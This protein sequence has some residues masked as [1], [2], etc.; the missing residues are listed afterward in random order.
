MMIRPA[1]YVLASL[2]LLFLFHLPAHAQ[3][4]AGFTTLEIGDSAPGFDLPGIDDKNHQLSQYADAKVL[5]VLFTCNHCPTAQAYEQRLN[6]LYAD[7]SGKGV[8]LV[9]ISPNDPTAVRLDELGYS[10]LGDTLAD[11]KV[12]AKQAG[13][14]YPY[15]YD[16]ENQKVSLAYGVRAT[17]HVF[18]FDQQRKLQYKG[19]IDDSEV[20]TPT[21]HDARNAIDAL[22]ADEEV[23]VQ[24][25]RPF[26]CSTKWM[27]KR[28]GAVESIK[29]WSAEPVE[30][31]TIDQAQLTALVANETDSYRLVN[32][33]ATWC[34]PCIEELPAFVE[35]NRMYRARSF[36][37]VTVC[38]DSIDAQENA[39]KILKDKNVSCRNVLFDS[40][41]DQDVLF[42]TVDAKWEGGVPYTLLIAP[43]GEIVYR[44][45]SAIDPAALKKIIAD[46]LG[47]T[48]AE[49]K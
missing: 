17:P 11:M 22:L 4:P 39:L 16:G 42:D 38:A 28:A 47:R 24:V 1:Q 43:G 21:S 40:T 33:W 36:E 23:P 27:T 10:D 44:Q 19:R 32:I 13:Y 6:E 34:V 29:K 26:G 45:H 5:M 31:S 37:M 25:T 12:R 41:E 15:L 14:K 8:A 7:Y 3:M 20:K 30:L 46:N 48:Y 35:M 49:Q 18:I 9:A 2:L